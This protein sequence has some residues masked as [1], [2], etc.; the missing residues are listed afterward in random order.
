M[1][2]KQR[3][4]A[5]VFANDNQVPRLVVPDEVA[6]MACEVDEPPADAVKRRGRDGGVLVE[7]FLTRHRR[8]RGL[9]VIGDISESEEVDQRHWAIEGDRQDALPLG[10]SR[11]S[12]LSVRLTKHVDAGGNFLRTAHGSDNRE[13]HR[14][15]PAATD[16][17]QTAAWLRTRRHA[18][19]RD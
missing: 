16:Q 18:R 7:C 9:P 6:V 12:D 17:I 13:R 1:E 4:R 10:R 19:P 14:H 5:R 15:I 8:I 11:A 3:V 2:R